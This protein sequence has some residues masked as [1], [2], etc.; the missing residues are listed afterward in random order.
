MLFAVYDVHHEAGAFTG[1]RPSAKVRY[2]RELAVWAK[3][4]ASVRDTPKMAFA[5]RL[6]V[7][8]PVPLNEQSVNFPS[9][10][11]SSPIILG[12]RTEFMFSS[13]F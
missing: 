2:S 1:L 6:V 12:P 5:L 7:I 13:A 8:G 3:A 10:L 11:E 4:L 9:S